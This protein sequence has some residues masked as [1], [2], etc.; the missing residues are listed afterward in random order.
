MSLFYAYG[1]ILA[2]FDSISSHKLSKTK[3]FSFCFE[4]DVFSEFHRIPKQDG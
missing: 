3:G 2:L 1:D 4:T